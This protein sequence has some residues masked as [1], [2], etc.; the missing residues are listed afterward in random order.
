MPT[1]I[2]PITSGTSNA[3]SNSLLNAILLA[4]SQPAGDTVII[5]LGTSVT[6]ADV[7]PAL[8]RGVIIDGQGLYS[9]NGAG[10]YQGFLAYSGDIIFRNVTLTNMV[11]TGGAGGS[12]AAGGGGG[13]GAGGALFVGPTANV[14]LENVTFSS[15]SAVGGAGGAGTAALIGAGGTGGG[16]GGG[17]GLGGAGGAAEVNN[18]F[19]GGGGG[20]GVGTSATGAPGTGGNGG[21]GIVVGADP[22]GSV[23]SGIGGAY[24][25]GGGTQSGRSAGGGGV[26][27]HDFSLGS[28]IDGSG[29]YGGGGGGAASGANGGDP[30]IYEGRNGGYGGGGGGGNGLSS[31]GSGGFGGGAGGGVNGTLTTAG[32]GGG[33]T[34]SASGGGGAGFGG[35]VFVAA[36]GTLNISGTTSFSGGSVTG[37]AAGGVGAQAGSAAGTGLYVN[38]TVTNWTVTGTQAL[39]DSIAGTGSLQVIGGGRLQLLADN[40]GYTGIVIV[41]TATL[42]LGDATHTATLNNNIALGSGGVLEFR[43]AGNSTSSAV[44]TGV[45]SIRNDSAATTT[46]TGNSASFA[47]TTTVTNGALQIGAGGTT[48]TLGGTISLQRGTFTL[49]PELIFNRS[50][51]LTLGSQVSADAYSQT[52]KTGAGNLIL[53][54]YNVFGGGIEVAQGA[55]VTRNAAGLSGTVTV[56]TGARFVVDTVSNDIVFNGIT[57]GVGSIEKIS[58]G[59]AQVNYLSATGGTTVSAGTLRTGSN[60][61]APTISGN[62]GVASGA[63]F[64]IYTNVGGAGTTAAQGISGAG[65]LSKTGAFAA[66]FTSVAMTGGVSASA[67]T[68]DVGSNASVGSLTVA[69]GA[70][71]QTANNFTIASGGTLS[72]AGTISSTGATG[73]LALGNVQGYTGTLTT[74]GQTINASQAAA[75][76]FAGTLTMSSGTGTLNFQNGTGGTIA[77]TLSAQTTV[78]TGQ[79]ATLTGTISG[80]TLRVQTAA[81]GGLTVRTGGT[82]TETNIVL[83]DSYLRF[84]RS[85]DVTLASTLT[86]VAGGTLQQAGTGTLTLTGANGGYTGTTQVL[87]GRLLVNGALGGTTT[88]STGA[89]LGGSGTLGAVTVSGSL[90]PGN[91]P[92]IISTGNLAFTAGA[93]YAVQIAGTAAG[94]YDRTNVTGTVTLGG[95]TLTVETLSGFA[96]TSGTSFTIIDNDGTDAVVGTFAGL[97]Q[98]G[99]IT[100][101]GYSFSINYAGGD[102]NDVVLLASAG[103]VRVFDTSSQESINNF[104]GGDYLLFT[105]AETA[106]N[107]QVNW[108]ASGDVVQITN[109]AGQSLLFSASA[110]A[111][112]SQLGRVQFGDGSSLILGDDGNNTLAGRATSDVIY[113]GPGNDTIDGTQGGNDFFYGGLGL[114]SIVGGAGNDHL[115]GAAASALAGDGADTIIGGAGSDYIQGN[116]GDDSLLGGLGSDR[117]FGG[118]GND[119]IFGEDGNDTVNGNLGNDVIDGGAGNDFLRGGQGDDSI[120]GSDGNDQL[121]GDLGN[122][123]LVGGVGLDILTGGDGADLFVFGAADAA[124]GTGALAGFYD[125][126]ADFQVGLDRI[127]LGFAV[128][129]DGYLRQGDGA[130]FSSVSAAQTYAQ[131]LMDNHTGTNEVA[132]VGVGADTYLF[133]SGAG[134]ATIDSTI[135]LIGLTPAA[136]S[137]SSFA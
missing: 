26:G 22:G 89:T 69:S 76:S 85:D 50:N 70:T 94:A 72:G 32:T 109:P 6:L 113:G 41:N 91:S 42:Q 59:L 3:G 46:L 106:R 114:D 64:E 101:G 27:G 17:G 39:S 82:L 92:G 30:Y 9:I 83:D 136:L 86:S 124:P 49:A 118:N 129:G 60:T 133:F 29:G 126:I 2:I 130:A 108:V 51:D 56:D 87:S 73:V 54:G 117:I 28:S 38:G 18:S 7:L 15:D 13:M 8:T 123:T 107:I 78:L 125:T 5:Q 11:A 121:F 55:L 16:G 21:T 110:L 62:V 74:A 79:A 88:V 80:D 23:N 132:A 52:L 1:T 134:G 44:F 63:T 102:G 65:T 115:Y 25:G 81:G 103:A 119:R 122:D 71:V 19:S 10:L 33:D 57:Q 77:G 99:I 98:G 104:A 97:A 45:G 131:Q 37:G 93:T 111:T 90:A 40:S 105:G 31:N 75:G 34:S 24:G 112:S 47:G 95:S 48:G 43:Q 14:T 116:A 58:A 53:A 127:Q 84:S 66:S 100:A 35:A 137:M 67:G 68:L 4:N 36:G 61:T 12:G 96:P 120:L 20:G 128:A 135:K